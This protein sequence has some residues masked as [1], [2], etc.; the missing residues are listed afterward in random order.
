M[1]RLAHKAGVLCIMLTIKDSIS[2]LILFTSLT[3]ARAMAGPFYKY[4]GEEGKGKEMQMQTY[5][6]WSNKVS[7]KSV[8][9]NERK[10]GLFKFAFE[11]RAR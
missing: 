5:I 10:T 7:A 8:D 2:S 3:V 9:E 11:L 6:C 1:A 4:R